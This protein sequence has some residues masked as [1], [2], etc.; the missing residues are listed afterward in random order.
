MCENVKK[1]S[2]WLGAVFGEGSVPQF[3]MNART[4]EILNQLMQS[5]E[6]SCRDTA[7]LIEDYK[8]KAAEY[9]AEGDH[10]QDILQQSLNLSPAS[11]SVSAAR[12]LSILV[13]SA[14][15]LGV[16]DTSL[17]SYFPA[18]NSL[19]NELLEAEKSNRKLKR[20]LK[21]VRNKV[22]DTLSR[23]DKI[24]VDLK[25]TIKLQAEEKVK[26]DQRQ[27]NMDFMK[28]KNDELSIRQKKSEA[29]LAALNMDDSLSHEAIESLSE[30]VA[31]L[32]NKI[33]PL[34][35]KLAS[36]MDLSP[37][38]CLAK[39]KLEEAK[40]QLVS[41]QTVTPTTNHARYFSG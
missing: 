11:L 5:S 17:S 13:E 15:V 10:L 24:K 37:N 7:L 28:A 32:H 26:V 36:Y 23:A 27:L 8:Q 6:A 38:P 41:L 9:H 34:R 18:I 1:V 33:N 22:G 16:R 25:K 14:V 4:V 21:A 12:Y 35:E 29:Q 2:S 19:T 40:R 39:V 30:E 31:A 3:E 20:E